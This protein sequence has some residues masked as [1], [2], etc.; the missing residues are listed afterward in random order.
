MS[1][2][3][4]GALPMSCFLHEPNFAYT[5]CEGNEF[6][7]DLQMF[8]RSDNRIVAVVSELLPSEREP[9]MPAAHVCNDIERIA[10]TL[11]R[12]GLDFDL[13]IE[14]YPVHG[15][16][17]GWQREGSQMEA[18]PETFDLVLLQWDAAAK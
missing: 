12:R 16:Y 4:I 17:T 14:H 13:L 18:I 7:V 10:T 11:A 8:Y 3:P 15:R 6:A 2:R 9:V 5:D 1:F